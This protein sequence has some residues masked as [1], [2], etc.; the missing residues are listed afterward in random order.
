MLA[1]SRALLHEATLL[2]AAEAA[3]PSHF[4][5]LRVPG[6]QFHSARTSDVASRGCEALSQSFLTLS[7]EVG[8]EAQQRAAKLQ[9]AQGLNASGRPVGPSTLQLEAQGMCCLQELVSKA[10]GQVQ[11]GL[12]R[13][14]IWDL[15]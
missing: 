10:H 1:V 11:Q 3:R 9:Q 12:Q 14:L 2:H 4:V 8:E 13:P 7:A 5:A 15:L 6:L